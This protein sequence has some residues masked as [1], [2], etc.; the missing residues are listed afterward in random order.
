MKLS[1]SHTVA[2]SAVLAGAI[3]AAV[4][5]PST[6]RTN[7]LK[8]SMVAA[9]GSSSAFLGA[10]DITVT[11]TSRHAVRVPKWQLPSDFVEQK[12]FQVSRDGQP[13]QY[14]GPMI[15]RPLP[16]AADFKVLRPGESY[17]TTVDLSAAYDL[18]RTGQYTVTYA[19]PLQHASMSTKC[20]RTVP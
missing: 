18:S 8:I 3:A 1:L 5:A 7:P 10:V 4:A 17:R 2:A 6:A 11:N 14:E 19:S 15:K 9:T 20:W 16:T 13:V 12:V